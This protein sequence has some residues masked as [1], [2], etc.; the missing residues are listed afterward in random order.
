MSKNILDKLNVA[1][2][3]LMMS[4]ALI[5]PF[6]LV[7]IISHA[8]TG[9]PIEFEAYERAEFCI[10]YGFYV[11]SAGLTGLIITRYLINKRKKQNLRIID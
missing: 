7:K 5:A 1:S 10:N 11:G 4:G 6:G 8:Y 9:K 2:T 3:I